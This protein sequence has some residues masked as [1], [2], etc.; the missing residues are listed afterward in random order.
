MHFVVVYALVA[1]LV[2]F[3]SA[4]KCLGML[5]VLL[6]GVEASGKCLVTLLSSFVDMFGLMTRSG[7]WLVIACL[8]GL[9]ACSSVITCLEYL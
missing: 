3:V 4:S 6:V 8:D 7:L 9:D 1:M 2:T 5:V